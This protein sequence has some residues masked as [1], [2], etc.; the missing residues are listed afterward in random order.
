MTS[1]RLAVAS[2]G[3]A[4]TST[5]SNGVLT[6]VSCLSVA[7]CVAVGSLAGNGVDTG[8]LAI[9]DQAAV[10]SWDGAN[11]SVTPSPQ[12]ALADGS[13]GPGLYGVSC[14]LA[15]GDAA[16]AAVGADGGSPAGPL[17]EETGAALGNLEPSTTTISVV[18]SPPD[19]VTYT[20]TYTV[21]VTVTPTT[22]SGTPGGS[23]AFD[24]QGNPI[25]GC[26]PQVLTA[27]APASVSCTV[28]L[29]TIDRTLG[30]VYSGDGTYDGS[31]ASVTASSG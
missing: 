2:P 12:P 17:V 4:A 9:P 29:G 20:V 24:L 5:I 8:G 27:T 1:P 26:P 31:S 25:P 3:V 7:S 6:A 14:T 23:V 22:G 16:C 19:P 15:K 18:A 28:F 11:W 21:T 30:A 10:E 13:A